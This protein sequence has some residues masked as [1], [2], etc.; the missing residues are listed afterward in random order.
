MVFKRT[1]SEMA[2]FIGPKREYFS[3]TY[4]LSKKVPSFKAGSDVYVLILGLDTG[5]FESPCHVV[6]PHKIDNRKIGFNGLDYP[7]KIKC[8]GL[9]EDGSRDP[10]ALCCKLAAMERERIPESDDYLKRIISSTAGRIHLPVLILGNSLGDDSKISYPI[11]KVSITKD[12]KNGGL[13]FAYLDVAT[14]TFKKEFI[15]A[16]GKE[17]KEDGVISYDLDEESPEFFE[18]VLDKLQ[19]AVIKIKGVTKEG[20]AATL[21]EYSFF[22]F[23]NKNIASDSGAG[24]RD[25]IVNYRSNPEIVRQISE[26]LALFDV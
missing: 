23:D 14:S 1:K 25:A 6:R 11:S 3:S 10:E 19:N 13:K 16:Y 9:R 22:S 26:F 24:E 7:V 12:L 15:G 4:R 8:K 20:F 5:F 17:L 2:S 21:K 18:V